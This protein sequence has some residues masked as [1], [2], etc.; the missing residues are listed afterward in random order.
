M[1][2]GD[3]ERDT[4][5]IK[6]SFLSGLIVSERK[7]KKREKRSYR[8]EL[9]IDLLRSPLEGKTEMKK[10]KKI[11]QKSEEIWKKHFDFLNV[12]NFNYI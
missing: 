1:F 10:E 5:H 12:P 6:T 9:L 2:G 7:N 11:I 4:K 3:V 8:R